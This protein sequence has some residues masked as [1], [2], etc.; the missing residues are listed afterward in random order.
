MKLVLNREM[1]FKGI[2]W[3]KCLIKTQVFRV[4]LAVQYQGYYKIRSGQRRNNAIEK[5][6]RIGIELSVIPLAISNVTVVN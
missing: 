5:A 2:N 3:N 4:F 1:K 6:A